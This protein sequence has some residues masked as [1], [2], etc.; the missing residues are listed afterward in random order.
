M[1]RL[2]LN[3]AAAE[4]HFE[5]L[6]TTIMERASNILNKGIKRSEK[7]KNDKGVKVL[8]KSAVNIDLDL[9]AFLTFISQETNLKQIVCLL[10]TDIDKF[11]IDLVSVHRI[12]ME[13]NLDHNFVIANIFLET[14]YKVKFQ[15]WDFIN[16]ITLDTCPYCNRNYIYAIS[17]KGKIKPQIDHFYPSS[18][19]PV[20]AVSFYNLIPCCQT[21][22]GLDAKKETDPVGTLTSPY[23]VKSNDFTFTYKLNSIDVLNPLAT[24]DAVEIKFLKKIDGHITVFKLE[25][26]YQK[27]A[28]HVLEL[29]I[30]SKLQ[31]SDTYRDYLGSYDDLK[32][33]E[34][35]IDRMILG[36]FTAE[37]EIHKR[38]F[39]KLYQDI[40]RELGLIPE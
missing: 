11:I 8:K 19:Y 37:E 14:A 9:S 24:K 13:N 12:D 30:K 5:E 31:Y 18:L 6:K 29:I 35:E 21:C 36:N 17:K 15:K 1:V 26:L 20:L 2:A 7:E 27:H 33:N 16:K 32:F 34:R 40:G 22:N 25:E 28:D 38:P 23:L 39:A 3:P 4:S 10:P